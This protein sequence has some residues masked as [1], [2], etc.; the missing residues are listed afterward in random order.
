MAD[1]RPETATLLQLQKKMQ[2]EN[3]PTLQQKPVTENNTGLPDNLKSGIENL[4]GY[5][6]DDVQVHYN[7]PAPAQLQAH[8]YAQGTDIHVAPGQEQHLPHE[9]WH[10]VQQK[11][12]RVQPT[13][14]LKDKI[15]VND[16]A[17]LEKEADVMGEKANFSEKH[18]DS[19][20]TTPPKSENSPGVVQ[21]VLLKLPNNGS[22]WE[23]DSNEYASHI[24]GWIDHQAEEL[25][26]KALQSLLI[27][28]GEET[29]PT[30]S[31]KILFSYAQLKSIEVRK[32][33]TLNFPLLKKAANPDV[34]E[35]IP[36]FIKA[37]AAYQ[38]L[39]V[40][41]YD[42]SEIMRTH[43]SIGLEF[44]F[45][46]YTSVKEFDSHLELAVSQP[47][48][49]LFN[50]PFVLETDSGK[51]LEIGF[52][53][54]LI[55]QDGKTKTR[56]ANIWKTMRKLMG[57]IREKSKGEGIP[58]LLNEISSAGLGKGWAY[59]GDAYKNLT[60][61]NER[62]K[63]T[64]TTDNVYSQLNISLTG[65]ESAQY[66][67]A[68]S[69]EEGLATSAEKELIIP[70]YKGVH[71]ILTIEKDKELI[72]NMTDGVFTH[73]TKSVTSMMAIPSILIADN[74]I[75]KE[76]VHSEGMFDLH[77][78]VKELHGI[79]VKDSLPNILR[80]MGGAKLKS[81]TVLLQKA[82]DQLIKYIIQ[83]VRKQLETSFREQNLKEAAEI[84]FAKTK[85]V[86]GALE[87]AIG[88]ADTW[89]QNEDWESH[90]K[91][92]KDMQ[93][94][95]SKL[96][97]FI[98]SDKAGFFTEF[99]TYK[100]TIAKLKSNFAKYRKDETDKEEHYESEGYY[101]LTGAS[102][103]KPGE[104]IEELKLVL[105]DVTIFRLHEKLVDLFVGEIEKEI[106]G[107]IKVL[108][109]SKDY[110]PSPKTG[111]N[112]GEKFGSG[113]GVRKDTH[114][115][116]V[117]TGGQSGKNVAELRGDSIIKKYVEN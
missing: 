8:A 53:P 108:K 9:A 24:K 13:L 105:K 1:N 86:T 56:I 55:V 74:P 83:Q 111:F 46:N 114:I 51:E 81:A 98:E 63:H 61:A 48:S 30:E 60:V 91:L 79:W 96:T 44:E 21:R 71:E 34:I 6:M 94:V 88:N 58:F 97:I 109:K 78:T 25:N 31:D 92:P 54:F 101:Y 26:Y 117:K 10:V 18:G 47:L 23:V 115:K 57:E 22:E 84:Y 72:E 16:D 107:T 66:I 19:V 85:D 65:E 75:L 102:W 93:D 49:P 112:Q 28:L 68:I 11:Q 110:L 15:N 7:S 36:E 43:Q 80:T 62:T 52:P 59:K 104:D 2:P 42:E 41:A 76:L 113:L 99:K 39:L 103:D 95:L 90:A 40:N 35:N 14:Q 5:S 69:Q 3:R 89:F 27:Q 45:A 29:K 73:L 38:K 67:E 106:D 37:Q 50:L 20:A 4:S 82:K 64:T 32:N 17:G 12:G 70:I 100:L 77:S 87:I 116:T 33:V